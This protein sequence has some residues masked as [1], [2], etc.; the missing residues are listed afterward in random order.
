[1]KVKLIDK[2][3]YLIIP[4]ILI[5]FFSCEDP[6]Q[7]KLDQGQKLL[8]IDAFINDLRQDQ[9]V[10]ITYSQNYFDNSQN[11]SVVD[12]A[13]VLLKDLNSNTTYTFTYKNDGYYTYT[14]SPTDTI[15][16][17][18]HLY[19]LLVVYN[20]YT[21]TATA[22]QKRTAVIDSIQVKFRKNNFTGEEG[23]KC[24]LWGRDVP[25]PIPDYYWIKSFKNDVFW[26]RTSDINLAYD[27]ASGGSGGVRADGYVFTPNIAE[28]ITPFDRYY[29]KG[30]TCRVEIHSLSSEECWNMFIQIINNTNNQGLFATTLENT[31]TNIITPNGSPI[32]AVG[33][34]NMASVI[35][36]TKVVN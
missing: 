24:I 30:D 14:L 27:G 9:Q 13:Q 28:A 16:K 21:Y 29:Q 12:N 34:F 7:I 31:K 3:Y 22:L 33:F 19:Q 11:V 8:V 1:M 4:V 26:G 17:V 23:Y 18:N 6:V 36:A 10:R 35:T 25:G 32:K 20:G 2:I 15:A 5:L